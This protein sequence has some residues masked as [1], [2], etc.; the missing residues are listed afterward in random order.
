MLGS[1]LPG[2]RSIETSVPPRFHRLRCAH[3][4]AVFRTHGLCGRGPRRNLVTAGIVV[5]FVIAAIVVGTQATKATLRGDSVT[6]TFAQAPPCANATIAL[7][8]PGGSDP[9]ATAEK[10]FAVLKPIE[11]MAT[12]TYNVKT[13]SVEVGYC[14]S[15]SNEAAIRQALVPTGLLATAGAE[16]GS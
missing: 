2:R 3:V 12:A 13:S 6:R 5:V 7:T 10:I 11:G 15:F 4:G 9:I 8:V 1:L 14:E 16:G